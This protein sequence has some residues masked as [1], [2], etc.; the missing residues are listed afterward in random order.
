MYLLFDIG[1]TN[2]RLAISRDGKTLE[3]PTNIPTTKDFDGGIAQ[4]KKF[5]NKRAGGEKITA[6]AGG[7]AGPLD[8]EKTMLV[9][10]PNIP[11]WAR[12]PL[13]KALE[14]AIGA[15]VLLEND[16]ALAGLGE[17]VFGAGQNFSIM[18]YITISTGIGGVRIID[19]KIDRNALGFEPGQQII[20]YKNG[21]SLEG[22]IS[23]SALERRFNKKPYEII[24]EVVWEEEARI[25]A[26]GLNNVIVHWSPDGI[27]LG[28]S[29]ILKKP[30]VDIHRVRFHLKN[31]LHI[32]PDPSPIVEA[33]L[34]NFGGLHGA[35]AYLQEQV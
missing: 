21:A 13:K 15:P 29:M 17:A 6:A 12:K 24:D 8:R 10:S 2:T 3:E 1:G 7:I 16:T 22:I 18:V 31:I 9:N 33:A 25:L 28:G 19:K 5:I 30:G 26:Y 34:A 20:D 35:L 11:D 14:D 4:L 23:G 27:V 32:F